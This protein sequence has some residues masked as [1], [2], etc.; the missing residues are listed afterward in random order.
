MWKIQGRNF[1]T[2][3]ED[4]VCLVDFGVHRWSEEEQL[5]MAWTEGF[6]DA[7]LFILDAVY[8][9]EDNEYGYEDRRVGSPS[10]NGIDFPGFEIRRVFPLINNGLRSEYFMACAIYDLWDGP[11]KGYTWSEHARRYIITSL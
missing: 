6:A 3:L 10:R 8:W 1:I 9:L 11:N 2:R 4:D 7:M 5:R